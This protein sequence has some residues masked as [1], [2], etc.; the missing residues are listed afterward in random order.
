[1]ASEML[2]D[3]ISQV[4]KLGETE[5]KISAFGVYPDK[6]KTKVQDVA[7]YQNDGTKNADGT[8][9]IKPSHFVERAAERNQY[10]LRPLQRAVGKWFSGDELALSKVGGK[11]AFDINKKVDRI[12]THRLRYSFRHYILRNRR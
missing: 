9:R 5:L 12:D 6:G 11:M 8:Q 4:E 10:W 1:M 7:F 2:S 3:L